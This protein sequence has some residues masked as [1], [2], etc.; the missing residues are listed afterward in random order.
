MSMV[1]AEQ[2]TMKEFWMMLVP[3]SKKTEV[4]TKARQLAEG[5][6]FMTFQ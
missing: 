6:R 4:H 3:E 2:L 1:D 5:N